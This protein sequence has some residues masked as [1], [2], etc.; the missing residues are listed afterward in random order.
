MAGEGNTEELPGISIALSANVAGLREGLSQ[1]K[2]ILNEKIPAEKIVRIKAQ[3]NTDQITSQVN[4]IRRELATLTDPK[5]GGQV[6][7]IDL[8]FKASKTGIGRLKSDVRRQLNEMGGI[9]VPLHFN[10]S[11]SEAARIRGEIQRNLAGLTAHVTLTWGWA[12]GAPPRLPRGFRGSGQGPVQ[13]GVVQSY[14]LA[15][16]QLAP[17]VASPAQQLLNAGISAPSEERAADQGPAPQE[18]GARTGRRPSALRK[19]ADETEG[20]YTTR[21]MLEAERLQKRLDST[22]LRTRQNAQRRIIQIEKALYGS[23]NRV[24]EPTPAPVRL[25]E[26]TRGPKDELNEN[27][28]IR[29]FFS[30]IGGEREV[31]EAGQRTGRVRAKKGSLLAPGVEALNAR[32]FGARRILEMQEEEREAKAGPGPGVRGRAARLYGPTL[33]LNSAQVIVL[34][35]LLA[36]S[37]ERIEAGV[38]ASLEEMHRK[39]GSQYLAKSLAGIN[40]LPEEKRGPAYKKLFGFDFGKGLGLIN[41]GEFQQ[42][43]EFAE[44]VQSEQRSA[45]PG[46]FKRLARGEPVSN[47]AATLRYEAAESLKGIAQNLLDLFSSQASAEQGTRQGA[48]TRTTNRVVEEFQ[49][50]RGFRP[51]VAGVKSEISEAISRISESGDPQ[52][53]RV[54]RRQS[55]GADVAHARQVVGELTTKLDALGKEREATERQLSIALNDAEREDYQKQLKRIDR[56]ISQATK[57]RDLF[58]QALGHGVGTVRKLPGESAEAHTARVAELANKYDQDLAAA[59]EA[60]AQ[61]HAPKT[62][63]EAG[64]EPIPSYEELTERVKNWTPSMMEEAAPPTVEATPIQPGYVAEGGAPPEYTGG[65]G[66]GG[67]PWEGGVVPVRVVNPGDI[68]A[69]LRTVL[70]AQNT[71]T[72]GAFTRGGRPLTDAEM[73]AIADLVV[74]K[75]PE[76]AAAEIGATY[77]DTTKTKG[78]GK[79]TGEEKEASKAAAAQKQRLG[80]SIPTLRGLRKTFEEEIGLRPSEIAAIEERKSPEEIGAAFLTERGAESFT[81]R[82]DEARLAATEAL[83]FLTSRAP[84]TTA[85]QALQQQIGGRATGL[86]KVAESRRLS[87]LSGQE[88]RKV[89]ELRSA[90]N[91]QEELINRTSDPAKVLEMRK[92]L[93]GLNDEFGVAATRMLK[94]AEESEEAAKGS[95]NFGTAVKNVGIGLV[96]ALSSTAAFTASFALLAGATATAGY[97]FAPLVDQIT[98]YSLTTGRVTKQLAEQARAQGGATEAVTAHALAMA[99]LS[100]EAAASISPLL[101]QRAAVEAGNLA[102]QEQVDFLHSARNIA[103]D[104]ARGGG[105]RGLTAGTG[106]FL[107]TGL[108]GIR[109]TQEL[110]AQGLTGAGAR[111][112]GSISLGGGFALGPVPLSSLPDGSTRINLA[113]ETLDFFN[114]QFEKGGAVGVRIAQAAEGQKADTEKVAQIFESIGA[115]DLASRIRSERLTVSGISNQADARRALQALNIAGQIPDPRLL[116]EALN[117]RVLPAQFQG[118]RARA[119]F[120]RQGAL[121]AQQALNLAAQP[122][123]P[124]G[125]TFTT[126]GVSSGFQSRI[127]GLQNIAV[128]AQRGLQGLA[129]QEALFRLVPSDERAEF[130]GILADI[131][132][133]GQQIADINKQV[134]QAQ[135][136]Q[137]TAEY[138][139]QLKIA[140][141]TLG[142]IAGMIDGIEGKQGNT[143]GLLEGQTIALQRQSQELQFQSQH[144]SQ[145]LAQRQ[146]NFQVAIAGFVAP[147]TTGEER[148]ARIDQAK[149]EAS[150]AQQQLDIQ[151]QQL[152]I[153]EQI[154]QNSVAVQ[155]LNLSRQLSDL[156]DQIGLLEGARGLTQ[157]GAAAAETLD[158]LSRK[159]AALVEQAGT[160]MQEG[161]E[162]A[163][164][165]I[166][167]A[168]QVAETTGEAFATILQKTSTAWGIFGEQAAQI[169]AALE[170]TAPT[171]TNGGYG[172]HAPG[173]GPLPTV[174]QTGFYGQATMPTTMT[175]GEAGPE[176]IAILR[177]PRSI[178]FGG[179]GGGTNVVVSVQINHPVIREDADL[180]RM[181]QML[182]PAVEQAIGRRASTLGLRLPG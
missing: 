25:A 175:V 99:G 142:D 70:L 122:F 118:I 152:A 60:Y 163:S 154:F 102:L 159:Q 128:G 108:F 8:H 22:R 182:V 127:A 13:A 181:A 14:V 111:P 176:T 86:L 156:R 83:Q 131:T 173:T 64:V 113:K 177:N 170:G 114:A 171:T 143:L 139:V 50:I 140:R 47:K 146:I 153:A 149:I 132:T 98:G 37:R 151:K 90:I 124:F 74:Q 7:P 19:R 109:S 130:A 5:K 80:Y 15:G 147:G 105:E 65:G 39:P 87:S 28:L 89:N 167:A 54:S 161:T 68:A 136:A 62:K 78:R 63:E 56:S 155:G 121:P 145:A 26:E 35:D 34:Q 76:A 41:R 100:K 82:L 9:N 119:Q 49:A 158:R 172:G 44:G 6:I 162:A 12:N 91:L 103:L 133:T 46:L 134:S 43:I 2:A 32:L 164:V 73:Q 117:Q 59:H 36:L 107:G 55:V 144:L 116:I 150:Y 138:N 97:V 135:V 123:L 104:T 77:T 29:A 20:Q 96:G 17:S 23:S 165:V 58:Q 75:G 11:A 178:Q 53:G 57:R 129:S 101:E 125:S 85:G 51:R 1:A 160:Y 174:Y 30:F 92:S 31:N 67:T 48:A 71:G 81:G 72:A 169:L 16:Q 79:K 69:A 120:Q 40:E 179:G 4:R 137:Q 18:A 27:E 45:K 106:G 93:E 126:E 33:K 148:A 141:R 52:E 110:L 112:G 66:G 84:G 94:F 157:F 115:G 38:A 95:A 24:V 88:L 166:Q 168:Q 10:P 61:A 42:A 3:L 180:Q 21:L